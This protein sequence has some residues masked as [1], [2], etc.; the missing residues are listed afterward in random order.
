MIQP[1]DRSQISIQKLSWMYSSLKNTFNMNKFWYL[2]LSAVSLAVFANPIAAQAFN[3]A[4]AGTE[5]FNVVANGGNVTAMFDGSS[6][7]Y[8]DEL[9][10]MRDASGKPGIDTITANDFFIFNNKS[11]PGTQVD[12]GS[13][14]DGTVLS[15]RLHVVNTD[16]DFFSGAASLNPDGLFHARAQGNYLGKPITTLVSFEDLKGG[17]FDYNDLSFTVTSTR[18]VSSASAAVPEPFTIVGTLIGGTAALRMRKKLAN[19]NKV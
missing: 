8:I 10:L 11:T 6:A 1:I 15:F 14:T 3:I 16:T 5:G 9:Y 7:G 12:L 17:P 19:R 13:F 4:N 2:S 18:A